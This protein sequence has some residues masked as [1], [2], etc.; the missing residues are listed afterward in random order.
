MPLQGHC[1]RKCHT[2]YMQGSPLW[3]PSHTHTLCK[4]AKMFLVCPAA[5]TPLERVRSQS[6]SMET[7]TSHQSVE[8]ISAT[9]YL[10]E[11]EGL[12]RKYY[13]TVVTD[14]KNLA[15]FYVPV[16]GK[17]KSQNVDVGQD[18]FS[19]IYFKMCVFFKFYLLASVMLH[20]YLF[21]VMIIDHTQ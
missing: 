16:A 2:N 11:N 9:R 19:F 8:V 3:K 14:I 10:G 7:T 1:T 17:T 20:S 18:L 6:V 5:S 15:P 4:L 21:L 12:L 13:S